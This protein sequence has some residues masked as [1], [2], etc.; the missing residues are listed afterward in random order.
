M[1]R[2]T[3]RGTEAGRDGE[4][5][6]AGAQGA[7]TVQVPTTGDSPLS[8]IWLMDAICEP[9][10]LRQALKRVKANKGAAGAD[11]ISVSE[12]PGHQKHYW[13]ELK[14]QLLSGSYL[15]FT[16]GRMVI[17]KSGGGK[18]LL[19]IPT[20]VDRFIQQAI[21]QVLQAQRDASLSDSS[22]GFRHG[23]SAHQAVKQ[24]QDYI[25]S[26]YHWVGDI[27]FSLSLHHYTFG[28][29]KRNDTLIYNKSISGI[30]I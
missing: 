30:M 18:R 20:F 19:G 3:H 28:F 17:P 25:S 14:A 7:E 4:A 27:T 23:R 26:G 22:C 21:M 8:A 16:P 13:P 12:L 15:P 10:N 5:P 2:K 9:V 6:D 24:V 29:V 1:Q 11:G